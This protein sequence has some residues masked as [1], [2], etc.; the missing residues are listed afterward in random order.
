M[1]TVCYILQYIKDTVVN[2]LARTLLA[3]TKAAG[4]SIATHTNK[5]SLRRTNEGNR[6]LHKTQHGNLE[7]DGRDSAGAQQRQGCPHE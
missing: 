2:D 4:R 5:K 7:H 6:F 3:Q 1:R